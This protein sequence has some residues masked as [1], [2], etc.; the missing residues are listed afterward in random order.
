MATQRQYRIDS[1]DQLEEIISKELV[2]C[3]AISIR[4]IAQVWNSTRK[5]KG[6]T[7]W[8]GKIFVRFYSINRMLHAEVC[9]VHHRTGGILM[10]AELKYRAALK[11]CEEKQLSPF[12][13][14][15]T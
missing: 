5:Q 12:E 1:P 8:D 6:A 15:V 2:K 4:N 3:G 14:V 11:W 9:R 7:N 13:E 10:C